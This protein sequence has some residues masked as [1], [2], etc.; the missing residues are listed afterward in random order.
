MFA[1]LASLEAFAPIVA[2][3]VFNNLYP[4]TL[5]FMPGF[6]YI[7]CALLCL[8][9]IIIA[10]WLYMDMKAEP[11]YDI[12]EEEDRGN[13]AIGKDDGIENGADASVCNAPSI[14]DAGI[15]HAVVLVAHERSNLS[16]GGPSYDAMNGMPDVY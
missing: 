15:T 2:T 7:V 12:M 6:C 5:H 1:F 4:V 11:E 10:I 16:S 14:Q 9:T 3:L 8:I 13:E